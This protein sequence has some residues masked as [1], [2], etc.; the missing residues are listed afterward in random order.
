M[1]TVRQRQAH[2][3]AL[4]KPKKQGEQAYP[5]CAPENKAEYLGLQ[6]CRAW[7]I[8]TDLGGNERDKGCARRDRPGPKASTS[9]SDGHPR[10][11]PS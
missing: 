10:T 3:K 6:G 1:S 8:A 4:L 7:S 2:L 9:C 11:H 5:N